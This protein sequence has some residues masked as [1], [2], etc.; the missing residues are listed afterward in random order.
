M[1]GASFNCL[2]ALSHTLQKQITSKRVSVGVIGSGNWGTAIAK[3]CGENAKAHP[4]LFN[5]Q[6]HM[7]MYEENIDHHGE[8]RKLTDVFNSTH[9]NV[10][11]LKGIQCPSNVYANPD[12]RDVGARSDILVWVL[13]H[14]FVV[15]VCDQLKGY[16]KKDAVAISCIKGISVN[17]DHV[18]LF[19]DIIQERTGMYC[20][21]LSG[22]N[23]ASE[24]A[25]EKFCETT[26]GYDPDRSVNPLYTA[27][28]IHSLFNRPYFRVQIVKDVPGV[29]LGGALKN[30]VAVAA[31]IID[32][33]ELGDNTKSAIMR[34]GLA[35]MQKFGAMFF[36]CDRLTM[37][38]QSCGI[39]DLITTC[40]G[41]RNRK[42]AV[43]FA[44]TGKP[45]HVLEKELLN[46][47]KLQGATTAKEVHE[48]LDHQN[49]VDE[50]PLFKAVYDIVY[51]GL[52][53]NKLLEAI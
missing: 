36:D 35:E 43:A 31:G 41:G 10:K 1:S 11:Y 29:A 27:E 13:P 18:C 50:F 44:K 19:S 12:I 26:I 48:F 33:L 16:L 15:R 4:D 45:M 37:S 52:P 51:E 23:I 20:G 40:L 47:Q 2:S 49:K 28:T 24:V 34:I 8:T 46:G 21:V 7:W 42:C 5:P 17:A 39:A 14:Q 9:E 22:A 6:V 25:K 32:G 30:I 38:E 3:I 53:A